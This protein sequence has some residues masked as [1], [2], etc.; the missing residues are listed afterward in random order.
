MSTILDKAL[1]NFAAFSKAGREILDAFKMPSEPVDADTVKDILLDH[2][3]ENNATVAKAIKE[4]RTL[5]RKSSK[6]DA[7]E[8]S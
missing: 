4:F 8:F 7:L 2:I 6:A 5:Q 3:T 1:E